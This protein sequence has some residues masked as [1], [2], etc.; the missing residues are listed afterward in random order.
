[1]QT[2]TYFLGANT[3][4]GFSSLYDALFADARIRKLYV[5]KGG[6]GCGKSTLM[7]TAAAAASELG[8]DTE[9]ILCSSDPDSLDALIVPQA[10][11]ALVDGTAPHVVEPPLCGL[12]AC[13]LDLG[14][15]YDGERLAKDR[16]ALREAK[17][18]NAACYPLCYLALRAA[19]AAS[20]G[21]RRI[22]SAGLP[23]TLLPE[24]LEELLPPLP[25]RSTAQPP[26]RRY[27]RG[28][29][30]QGLLSL[31]SGCGRHVV[32]RDSFGLSAPLLS[33]IAAFCAEQGCPAVLC[34]DPLAPASLQAVLIPEAELAFSAASRLYPQETDAQ[35]QADLDAL[36]LQRLSYEK[37]QRLEGLEQLRVAAVHEALR[38]LAAAKR[39]H[40]ALEALYR[41]AVD[42]DGVSEA[43]RQ[44][45]R[46]LTQMLS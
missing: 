38:H 37:T 36:I 11:L 41:P 17:E 25:K 23:P 46:T 44:L 13:Y 12:G 24:L 15:F 31:P 33:R 7:R 42:F 32:L 18:K 10:G 30:P 5:L 39:H 19:G 29:T 3:P 28:V 26:L 22:A 16:E 43:A 34:P 45:V 20:E 6:P 14:R 8:C 2:R 9:Q 35:P 1:M 4:E 40:D 21:L 27:L